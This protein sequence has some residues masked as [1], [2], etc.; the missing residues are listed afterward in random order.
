MSKVYNIFDFDEPPFKVFPPINPDELAV[1]LDANM[2]IFETWDNPNKGRDFA[3]A[4]NKMLLNAKDDDKYAIAAINIAAAL[5][6]ER[7]ENSDTN[8]NEYH[9]FD[10]TFEVMLSSFC[11]ANINNYLDYQGAIKLSDG[12][13]KVLI[14]AALMH[15]FKHTG[16]GNNGQLC[17]MELESFNMAEKYLID[18]GIDLAKRQIIKAMVLSTDLALTGYVDDVYKHLFLNKQ[19][20]KVDQKIA[21]FAAYFNDPKTVY[22]SLIL[23]DADLLSSAGLSYSKMIS[24]TKKIMEE[25][26]KSGISPDD[27]PTVVFNSFSTN[28]FPKGFR[29]MPG[30]IFNSNY[31]Q[32]LEKIK[33]CK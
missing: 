2:D 30:K 1:A 7:Q 12:D 3:F 29:S 20:P 8:E 19:K 10:H 24:Q 21:D 17:K 23:C 14:I 15:D 11:M 18:A 26:K 32:I 4:I 22:L 33:Y 27:D 28:C 25:M 16:Q 9:N 6:S 5:D 31:Y 13:K